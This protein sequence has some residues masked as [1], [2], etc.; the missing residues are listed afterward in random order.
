MLAHGRELAILS[1]AKDLLL[2][3]ASNQEKVVTL[4]GAKDML[5]HF[6]SNQNE[7]VILSEA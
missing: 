6:A 2:H 3:F 7:V 5:L 4:S 1:K